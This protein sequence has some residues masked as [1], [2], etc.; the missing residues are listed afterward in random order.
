MGRVPLRRLKVVGLPINF[1][2]RE[3]DESKM[4]FKVRLESAAMPF[5][6]RRYVRD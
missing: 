3:A 1:A 2:E 4:S 5:R 6:L